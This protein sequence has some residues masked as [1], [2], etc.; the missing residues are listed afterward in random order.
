[1]DLLIFSLKAKLYPLL[2][3]MAFVAALASTVLFTFIYWSARCVV[4][5]GRRKKY[6]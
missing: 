4:A 2:S 1:M 6:L 3:Y 5:K